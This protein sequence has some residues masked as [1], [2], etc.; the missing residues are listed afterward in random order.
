MGRAASTCGANATCDVTFSDGFVA[1]VATQDDAHVNTAARLFLIK[2]RED[3]TDRCL[4]NQVGTYSVHGYSSGPL[5]NYDPLYMCDE[6]SEPVLIA[7]I[8]VSCLILGL[9][10]AC[11]VY[12]KCRPNREAYE[13]DDAVRREKEN[14]RKRRRMS[15]YE[16]GNI[17]QPVIGSDAGCIERKPDI[18]MPLC[19]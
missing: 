6:P 19:D 9:C 11:L 2:G 7:V 12:Y 18:L 4:L 16:Y 3:E 14:R 17:H 1:A 8:L 13:S 5:F 10:S 15:D